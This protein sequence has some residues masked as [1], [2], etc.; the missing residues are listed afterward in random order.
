MFKDIFKRNLSN[1]YPIVDIM[2][3]FAVLLMI[4]FHLGFDL[5]VF[6]FTNF[7]FQ[8]DLFWWTFPRVIVTLF[9]F[10]MGQSLEITHKPPL[11]IKKV[12]KRFFKIGG[13]AVM[14]SIFTYFAFPTR[15][16]YFGTL[17]CI[18]VCSILAIPFLNKRWASLIGAAVILLPLL[19]GFHWPWPQMSH[20]SMDY[21]PALPWLGVVLLGMGSTHFSLHKQNVTNFLGR[22]LLIIFGQHSLFIYLIHQPILFGIVK[23]IYTIAPP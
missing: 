4:I 15:W 21:I 3:G 2:R 14:I 1:R 13:F 6:G 9:L 16:I 17:H 5:T 7:D 22:N 10:S 18:A 11:K 20:A 12:L 8:N 19:L 23:I